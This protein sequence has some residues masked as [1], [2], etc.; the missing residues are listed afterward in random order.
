MHE[1]LSDV[2]N[3]YEQAICGPKGKQWNEVYTSEFESMI[4]NKVFVWAQ[5][6]TGKIAFPCKWLFV[7]K[8]RLDGTIEKYKARIVAGGHKQWEGIDFQETYTPVVKFVSLRILLAMAAIDDLEGE[9]CDIVTAFLYG[10]LDEEVYMRTP[11]GIT[12]KVGDHYLTELGEH[13]LITESNLDTNP[14]LYWYLQKSLYGLRQPPRCFYKKLDSILNKHGYKRIASDYVV[15]IAVHEAL[16]IV[17]VDDMLLLG[18]V[19]GIQHI[20]NTLLENFLI[21]K[22]RPIGTHLFLELQIERDQ[23]RHLISISQ[24]IYARQILQRFAM[25][26]CTPCSIPMDPKEDWCLKKDDVPLP[27]KSIY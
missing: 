2:P 19:A 6:P 27:D 22:M 18:T 7:V 14:P 10:D 17:H 26:N 24:S 8:R 11:L 3:T 13:L 20:H 12:P 1:F 23:E 25:S 9:Q 21:K 4:H 15:W 5:L 16:I